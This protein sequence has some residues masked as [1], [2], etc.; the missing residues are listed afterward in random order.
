[1]QPF[2]KNGLYPSRTKAKFFIHIINIYT[3]QT[4]SI[5]TQEKILRTAS[6]EFYQ[7][8]IRSVSIDDICKK[9]GM[10]KKTFY[11]YYPTKD[12]LVAAIL[13]RAVE[14]MDKTA[15][16]MLN[17]D[18]LRACLHRFAANQARDKSDVRKVPLLLRD[19]KK[20]YPQ[21]FEEYQKR[22]FISQY[23]KVKKALQLGIEDHLVRSDIN[24]DLTSLLFAK[25][26][27]DTVRHL[28][29]LKENKISVS[30]YINNTAAILIRGILSPEGLVILDQHD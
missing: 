13:D 3:T 10:S 25:I 8:G 15:T 2:L 18:N 26:H 20:Y 23:E 14:E 12:D 5:D 11:T 22:V 9:L 4:M 6:E 30:A 29:L 7:F 28:E 21:L 24:V 17:A 16:F 27:A 1:M 19:L